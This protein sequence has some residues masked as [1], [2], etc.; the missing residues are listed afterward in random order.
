MSTTNNIDSSI[1]SGTSPFSKNDNKKPPESS[2][3]EQ[4][5]GCVIDDDMSLEQCINAI[6]ALSPF[7]QS[8]SAATRN[9]VA[10]T[11]CKLVR[12]AAELL[13]KEPRLL[14]TM[15]HN[16]DKRAGLLNSVIRKIECLN[17]EGKIGLGCDSIGD[18]EVAKTILKEFLPGPIFDE[19]V[20]PKLEQIGRDSYASADK[21]VKAKK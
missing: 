10:R 7:L 9:S 13:E 19:F 16:P 6:N 12:K 2:E 14:E 5:P 3:V 1:I 11:M 15:I 4:M 18:L 20:N 21:F 8:K 17:K